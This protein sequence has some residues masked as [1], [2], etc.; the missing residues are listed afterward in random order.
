MSWFTRKTAP[1][2]SHVEIEM[3]ELPPRQSVVETPRGRSGSF[4]GQLVAHSGWAHT[5]T[6]D[7]YFSATHN[8]MDV[9]HIQSHAPGSGSQMMQAVEARARQVGAT[10]MVTATSRPGFF[11]KMGFDYTEQQKRTNA[12]KEERDPGLVARDESN[13]GEQGGGGYGMFKTL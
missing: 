11:K 13:K 12:L 5:G 6:T 8:T 7:Y 2:P 3:K 9:Q 10:E 1:K 4:S